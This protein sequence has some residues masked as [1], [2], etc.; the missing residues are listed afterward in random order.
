MKK[1]VLF[2]IILTSIL[3]CSS[4]KSNSLNDDLVGKWKLIG[5]VNETN[6]AI[7][8]AS[9]FE[10]SNEITIDFKEDFNYVGSTVLNEFF[11][12]YLINESKDI[13]IFKG[14][15][16][17]EVNETE[18]GH[19]FYDNLRLNYNQTTQSWDNKYELL[20]DMLKLYYSEN[21]FM[22]FEKM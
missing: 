15:F 19:L 9:D 3:G 12:G 18:W 16:T 6:G 13:L 5:F 20:D 8:I 11:G 7:L 2:I 1:A 22:K 4:D 21:E 17:T 10:N 14:F